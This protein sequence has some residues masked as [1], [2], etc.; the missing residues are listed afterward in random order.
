MRPK[1]NG[2]HLHL[3]KKLGKILKMRKNT[4]ENQEKILVRPKKEKKKKKIL[5]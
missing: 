3:G 2:P 1:K 5:T 4:L